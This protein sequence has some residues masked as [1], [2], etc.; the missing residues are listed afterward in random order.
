MAVMGLRLAGRSNGVAKL[1]GEVSREMFGDLWPDVPA[2]EVPITSVTNGVHAHTWVAPEMADL[3]TRHVLPE[4]HE[5]EAEPLGAPRRGPRRRALAGPRAG[6][7][8]SSSPSCAS[9]CA[10]QLM[11]RGLS[12]S[13]VEWTDSVLDPKALTIGF[14]RRFA[15]YKRATLLLSQPERL[16]ALLLSGDRPVQLV[17][18]GKSHPADDSGKELIRQ[19]VDVRR[20]PRGPPPRS[21]SSRTTTSPSPAPC[22]RAPTCGS[23]TP[24]GRRRRA[25]RRA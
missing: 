13:D 3:L 5:A 21:C 14:A 6:P 12:A 1:H 15:T 10:T 2:D 7:R 17:F 24:V 19:I 22:S 11:A 16:R 23:T 25:A 4:W 18:A 20:R 9:G 8:G